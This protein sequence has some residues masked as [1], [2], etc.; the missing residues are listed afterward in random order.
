MYVSAPS[1]MSDDGKTSSSSKK[2]LKVLET[3]LEIKVSALREVEAQVRG[4][5]CM[6]MC[7][8]KDRNMCG[9]VWGVLIECVCIWL[10]VA[11]VLMY[12]RVRVLCR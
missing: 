2:K 11:C 4:Y 5:I 9:H 1:L 8:C 12:V 3:E 10:F 6:Q 7:V